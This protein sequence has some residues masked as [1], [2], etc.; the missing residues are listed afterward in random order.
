MTLDTQQLITTIFYASTVLDPFHTFTVQELLWCSIPNNESTQFSILPQ[1]MTLYTLP[2][3]WNFSTL[4]QSRNLCGA[5]YP[6]TDQH[7]RPSFHDIGPFPYFHGLGTSHLFFQ[8]SLWCFILNKGLAQSSMLSRY[9]TLSTLPWRRNFST[10]P[11]HRNHYVARY[12]TM[13]K[14]NLLCFHSVGPL[15]HFHDVGTSPPFLVQ[16]SLRCSIH[17]NG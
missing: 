4:R 8:E 7:N 2:R 12:P 5:R 13:D 6:A 17:N 15:P 11:W 9:R 14:H 10:F 16:E 1:C 3:C